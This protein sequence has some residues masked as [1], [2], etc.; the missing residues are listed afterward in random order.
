MVLLEKLIVA[1]S[2]EE[3]PSFREPEDSLIC[4]TSQPLDLLRIIQL[5]YGIMKRKLRY[6]E[7]HNLHSSPILIRLIKS[8]KIRWAGHVGSMGRR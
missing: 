5:L 7:L 1:N 3:F 8:S 6:E 4:S 2:F